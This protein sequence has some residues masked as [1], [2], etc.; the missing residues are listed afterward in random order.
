MKK[1]EIEEIVSFS[2][3][4]NA[5]ITVYTVIMSLYRLTTVHEVFISAGEVL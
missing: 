1:K 3:K 2:K 5:R 4:Y